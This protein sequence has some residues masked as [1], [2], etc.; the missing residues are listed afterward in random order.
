LIGGITVHVREAVKP[1]R[2]VVLPP[3][4]ACPRCGLYGCPDDPRKAVI[5]NV[6][7][8]NP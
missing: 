1:D 7:T 4:G 3:S 2:I 8:R 5:I 6:G